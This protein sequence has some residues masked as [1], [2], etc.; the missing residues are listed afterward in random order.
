MSST[1]QDRLH[2]LFFHECG[3]SDS[4]PP[5]LSSFCSSPCTGSQAGP[6]MCCVPSLPL[7]A[8]SSASTAALGTALPGPRCGEVQAWLCAAVL[9]MRSSLR[10]G[11]NLMGWWEAPNTCCGTWFGEGG[12]GSLQG[13]GHPKSQSEKLGLCSALLP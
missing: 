6:Q 3:F 9:G 7:R 13:R 11:A 10:W 1:H 5:F 2:D 4:P 12:H 8:F